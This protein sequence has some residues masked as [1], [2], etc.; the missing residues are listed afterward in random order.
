M[1]EQTALKHQLELRRVG[2]GEADTGDAGR[3]QE[4]L[5][6]RFG[7]SRAFLRVR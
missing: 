7:L 2:E 6:F 5:R 4:I 3:K 1:I